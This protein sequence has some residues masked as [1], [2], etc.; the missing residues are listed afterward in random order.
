MGTHISPTLAMP[1][2][3]LCPRQHSQGTEPGLQRAGAPS[4]HCCHQGKG[5]SQQNWGWGKLWAVSEPLA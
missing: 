2:S 1:S 4:P 3:G 5:L